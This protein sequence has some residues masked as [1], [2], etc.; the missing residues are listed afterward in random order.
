MMRVIEL[1]PFGSR[2]DRGI[3]NNLNEIPKDYVI[4]TVDDKESLSKVY[5]RAV[6]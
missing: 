5:G 4:K 2:I 1:G 6:L 3:I